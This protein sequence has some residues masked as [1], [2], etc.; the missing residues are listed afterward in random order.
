M[1]VSIPEMLTFES[2]PEG[3]EEV[4]HTYKVH[5]LGDLLILAEAEGPSRIE[6][7]CGRKGEGREAFGLDSSFYSM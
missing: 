4:S 7:R 5:K 3:S 1:G 6:L 2:N